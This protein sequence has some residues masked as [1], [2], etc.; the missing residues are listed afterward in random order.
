[1]SDEIQE[2]PWAATR[3]L[4]GAVGFI[5]ILLGGE[6]L[7]DKT[8]ER[9]ALGLGLA[10]V[11]IPVF[12]VGVFWKW[13]Q[14]RF[15]VANAKRLN[16]IAA[17]PIWWVALFAVFASFSFT[18]LG[19][20]PTALILVPLGVAYAIFAWRK[21]DRA[22]KAASYS[23]QSLESVDA[24]WRNDQRLQIKQDV[25]HLLDF[26]VH[27]TTLVMLNDLVERIPAIY[28]LMEYESPLPSNLA[29]KQAHIDAQEYLKTVR[30]RICDGSERASRYQSIMHSAESVAEQLLRSTPQ[31]ERPQGID[32]LELRDYAISFR[33]AVYTA[34]FLHTEKYKIEALVISQRSTLIER[35]RARN[36]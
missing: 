21:A 31:A 10:A 24:E 27:Q 6:I 26:G 14:P 13:L 19:L 35:F 25:L 16:F 7:V 11:G 33:Q 32:P 17:D 20:G 22:E 29:N 1:M 30:N 5:L 28:D 3:N 18:Q 2:T 23:G 8:G 15:S 9:F 34:R 36:K 4:L 12:F